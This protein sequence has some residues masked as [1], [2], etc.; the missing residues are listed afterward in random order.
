MIHVLGSDIPHHNPTVLRFFNDVLTP[1]LPDRPVFWVA[2]A[3]PDR[4]G[5][6]PRL[7]VVTYPDRRGL[8]RALVAHARRHRGERFFL[9]GQFAPRIW[10]AL[11]TGALRPEQVWWHIWG[12]DLYDSGTGVRARLAYLLRRPAQGRVGQVF[13]TLGDLSHDAR[14]HP[15]VPAR[16]LYFPTRMPGH[17]LPPRTRDSGQ[18]P[19]TVVIGNSGDPGNRHIEALHAVHERLGPATRVVIPFGYPPGND[20]YARRVREAAERL[21]APG[22]VRMPR[23]ML[24]LDAYAALLADCDLGTSPS[25]ASRASAP[26]AC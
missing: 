13:G 1:H 3:D 11:L 16:P 24:D 10:L 21:F 20:A 15:A 8:S 14:R 23:E 25:A 4:L 17:A 18:E 26:C 9:H 7:D 22:N 5:E 19:L 12:G 6:H 2:C